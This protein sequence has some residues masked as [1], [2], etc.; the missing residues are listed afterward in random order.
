MHPKIEALRE[1]A[2]LAAGVRDVLNQAR[3]ECACCGL[4]VYE[5]ETEWHWREMLSAAIA[6]L[7]KVAEGLGRRS[8]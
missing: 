6:R 7:E 4:T 2:R 1:A 3:H 8:G 5:D